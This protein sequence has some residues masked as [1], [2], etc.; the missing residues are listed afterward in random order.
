MV[1]AKPLTE[2]ERVALNLDPNGGPDYDEYAA[3]V[4]D[5]CMTRDM[6]LTDDNVTEVAQEVAAEL[7]LHEDTLVERSVKRANQ[8]EK[9]GNIN[10]GAA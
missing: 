6:E 9:A 2:D 5:R 7:V 4:I 10:G 8:F 1:G 3:E